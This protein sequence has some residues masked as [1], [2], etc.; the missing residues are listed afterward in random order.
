[1]NIDFHRTFKKRYKK[2]PVKVRS[3]FDERL[4]L[5]Q[6]DS[7]HPLLSHH[8]LSGDRDGQWSINIT[9]DWRALYVWLEPETVLFID[10]DTHSNLYG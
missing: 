10:I 1:M 7:S 3:Q 9:G 8:P 5:F 6:K 2:I 4:L